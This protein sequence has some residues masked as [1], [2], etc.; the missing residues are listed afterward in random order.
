MKIKN[1]ISYLAIASALTMLPACSSDYLELSPETE[2]D[3]DQIGKSLEAA[4]MALNGL[5]MA[6]NTQYQSTAYNQVNGEGYIQTNFNDGYGADFIGGLVQHWSKSMF[7]W[8]EFNDQDAIMNTLPWMYYY[9]LINQ[10]NIILDDIDECPGDE[11]RRGFIKA[12]ALTFRAHAYTRLLQF[13]APRWEDSRNGAQLCLVLRTQAGV[14][15]QPLSSMADVIKQIYADLDLAIS[16][17]DAASDVHRDYKWQVD[18]SVAR[19]VYARAA[20]IRHD[21]AIAQKMAHDARKGYA[22]MDNNTYLSGFYTDNN[23]NM[24]MQGANE[25][26]I[27]YWSWGSHYACNGQYVNSWGLGGIAISLDLYNQLDPNDIRRKLY[28][29][30]DKLND[31]DKKHNRGKITEADFWDNTLVDGSSCDMSFGPT[32]KVPGDASAKWGL[33]NVIIAY[34]HQY[35]NTEF[36]GNLSECYDP[37]QPFYAFIKKDDQNGVNLGNK[38]RF[39]LVVCPIG[40]SLKF[41]SVSPYGVN[42]MPFMRAS[43][44]CITEAEAAYMAGDMA[45]AVSCLEEINKLRIPGYSCDKTGDALLDEIRLCRRIELWG[46]GHNFSDWKRW[47]L[48][49]VRR[50]WVPGDPTSGNWGMDYGLEV[51]QNDESTN[52][53]RFIIPFDETRFNKSVNINEFNEGSGNAW[54]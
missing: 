4:Q 14:G 15:D 24:W 32:A 47:N 20:L 23:D 29:T 21:W 10:A 48:P 16:L 35:A 40:S 41:W 5:S 13:Y 1:K 6:M 46:E 50:A 31:I 26:D 2:V 34:A 22:V 19:G 17:Y 30:P 36:K 25:E 11:T 33:A 52:N 43:E 51:S 37:N 28:L 18:G 54:N 7:N 45:T 9:N 12:G 39:S 49:M 3:I 42:A 8:E 44:M 38:Q 27:Y 53:W